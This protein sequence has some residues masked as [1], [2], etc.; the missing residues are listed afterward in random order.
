MQERTP[1]NGWY[2]EPLNNSSTTSCISC[3]ISGLRGLHLNHGLWHKPTGIL[4]F[5]HVPATEAIDGGTRR[6][7][8]VFRGKHIE[9]SISGSKM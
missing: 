4:E 5:K 6:S 9:I 2:H 3:L 8:K 7:E 1:K